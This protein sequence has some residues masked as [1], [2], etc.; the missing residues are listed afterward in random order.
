MDAFSTSRAPSIRRK[1]FADH[2]FMTKRT[3]FF[4]FLLFP[5]IFFERF[6]ALNYLAAASLLGPGKGNKF[7]VSIELC[8]T[9]A[10]MSYE[11]FILSE[12]VGPKWLN[13]NFV[14]PTVECV[15]IEKD[16]ASYS[17]RIMAL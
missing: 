16:L 10:S 2:F 3:K 9:Q 12:P 4:S 1:Y 14:A 17:K 15:Q 8:T 5:R 7:L 11:Q 6:F 13:F